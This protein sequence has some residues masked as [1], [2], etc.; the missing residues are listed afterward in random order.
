MSDA[1][2]R[3]VVDHVSIAVNRLDEA[4]DF[5]RRHFPLVPGVS[6]QPG[7]VPEF[8]WCDF[9]VGGFKLELIESAAP[10]SFVARFLA[11]RGPGFHHWSLYTDRLPP[12][13]ARMEADGLRVVDKYD[14]GDGNVTAFLSPRSAF[15]VLI[16]FWQVG[17]AVHA[18]RSRD[19]ASLTL[20]TGAQ[21]RMR[22]DHVAIAVRDIEAALRF[23]ATYFPF[24]LR[25][26]PHPGW[27]GTFLIASFYVND[28]KVELIQGRPGR[29]SFVDRF[30]ERRGEGLHHIA[31]DI[32]D[33]DAYVAHLVADGVRVVDRRELAGG[34]KTA[35]I[36][37]R[38]AFG[39]LI[40]L[41]Q[42][43]AFR[44]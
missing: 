27:D 35:F 7:Y 1:A 3:L 31:I 21:V 26:P 11:R 38:S 34:I 19:I 8:N 41:W 6:P 17:E 9:Y 18:P 32:D 39:T 20:A 37:P 13:I 23:F 29:A 42:P 44:D 25:R 40:Q 33:L 22:V 24:R 12:L 2:P 30:I 36:S 15:G 14:A 28:Y 5:F 10:E 4:Y 43:T 16:Q